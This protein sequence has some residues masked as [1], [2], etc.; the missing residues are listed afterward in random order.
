MPNDAPPP[1]PATAAELR[2]RAAQ[3]LSAVPSEAVFDPSRAPER[4]DHDLNPTSYPGFGE[5]PVTAQLRPAAV[6]VP[7]IERPAG[8]TV[9]LTR[10]TD[11]L[12]SHPGQVAFPGG[13]IEPGD[14]TPLETAL[15][16]SEEE[17]GLER[18]FVE[19]LGYLD[20]Y[21]TGT[22]YRVVPVVAII[23]HGFTLRLDPSEVADAFEVPLAFL[24]DP[25][26]HERHEREWRGRIRS[27]YVMPF[28]HRQIWGATAGMIR[29][30][31]ERLLCPC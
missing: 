29:N 4:G 26:N 9:L 11:H 23:R 8:L 13:K 18:E 15:R 28:E 19:P 1:L 16:E 20:C 3:R 5:P 31:Y 14:R 12:P 7:I 2:S 10:R 27:Y 21:Q 22:G 30:L 6:L 25:V 24:M 17:I